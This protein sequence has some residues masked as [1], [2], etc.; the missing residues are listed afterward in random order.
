VVK[1]AFKIARRA[2]KFIPDVEPY[3]VVFIDARTTDFDFDI[4]P[5]KMLLDL[6]FEFEAGV[7]SAQ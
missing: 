2:S 5:L 1:T 3:T 6:L 4:V 7:V